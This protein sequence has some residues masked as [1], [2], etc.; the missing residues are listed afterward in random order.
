MIQVDKNHEDIC[1]P[2]GYSLEKEISR[3][4]LLARSLVIRNYHP[5]EVISQVVMGTELGSEAQCVSS[6]SGTHH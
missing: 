2:F 4:E 6:S 1:V 5:Q 3:G